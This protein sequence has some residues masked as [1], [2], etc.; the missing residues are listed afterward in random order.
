MTTFFRA[1]SFAQKDAALARAVSGSR[2]GAPAF[3][4]DVRA[5]GVVPRT[6][7]PYWASDVLLG[8]FECMPAL[9]SSKRAA[10]CGMGTLDNFR[11]LRC[12]WE[13]LRDADRWYPIAK[14][15]EFSRY[16]S[17]LGLVVDWLDAGSGMKC[18]VE[19][20]VGSASRKI[21][22][23]SFYFR[24][25]LT[26][27]HRTQGG[28]SIRA[29]PAGCIV[30][31][32]GPAVFYTGDQSFALLHLIALLNSS[33]FRG[34]VELQMTFGSYEVGV[35]QRTP[36][37][38]LTPDDESALADLAHRAWSIK[39][40]LDTR[41]E[42]SHAFVL[43]ALLQVE[44]DTL[45]ARAGAW[46]ERV[47][48][49]D[50]GLEAI[51]AEID[52]RCFELYGIGEEDRRAITEGFGS[53]TE[54]E[55][56]SE[57][58]EAEVVET[59]DAATL[60]AELVSWA[61]GVAIGRFDV[62]LATG[63]RDLPAE[64]DPFEAL[65]VCSAAM[66]TGDDGLPLSAP[67][68]GYP[69]D[70]PQDGILV[71]DA[72]HPRDLYAAVRHVFE[73]AFGS[74]ADAILSEAATML[75]PKKS[76]LRAWLARSFFESHLKRY[77]KSRRKA[78]ILWQL[79]TPSA[80]YS[81]W[82]YAHRLDSDGLFRLRAD[83]IDPKLAMEER[84]L[85]ALTQEA[86]PTPTASQ[87]KAIA[88]AEMLVE[89]LRA[90]RDE[91]A[92]VAPL[93]NPDLDDGVVIAMSPLWRLVPQ[94]R[95]W[96]KELKTTFDALAV[97]KYDWAHL[98]MHLWPERVVPKCA[99]DRS[100]AIAHGLEDVFWVEGEDGKWSVRSVSQS[101]IDSLIAER[102]SPA[103]ADALRSLLDAS[104]ASGGRGKTR[105]PGGTS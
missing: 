78:P 99:A 71:D 67:P 4:R 70:F 21:Q 60:A 88:E 104:L 1:V 97:G 29:M 12:Y 102:T 41:T 11:F 59:V 100:P 86:G 62:R 18:F 103:V 45:V 66:L 47:S 74:Q 15:G 10:R 56:P 28:F 65:P 2:F 23:E 96:Q 80:R 48:K 49:S 69:I 57:E 98:A 93:W 19:Q 91:I 55:E 14:G 20:K 31:D 53:V 58:A 89:E 72:G 6:P 64:P 34:L 25:G 90:M 40:S 79:A 43:P 68:A 27:S 63:E 73:V 75:D 42:T 39:R 77:S 101:T 8:T 35:I 33:A 22:A 3:V 46:D 54:D 24:P 32:K 16:Y 84:R 17:D 61:V 92:R 36:V 26:W 38:D 87:G 51:Q 105:K 94:H 76:D 37:P 9:E 13:V 50:A 81:V 5:F 44:G 52:E 83:V 82:L 7:F 85:S 95:T 30:G